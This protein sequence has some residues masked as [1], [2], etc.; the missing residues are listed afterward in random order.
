[1]YIPVL[2]LF[3]MGF[4]WGRW[5]NISYV[6]VIVMY[7]YLL[8]EELITI[9]KEIYDTK[10]YNI[11]KKKMFFIFVFI[12]FCFG[13]NPKTVIT[14]DIATNPLWKVPYNASKIIFG[15]NSYRILQDSPI[16]NWHKK[17]IE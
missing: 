10:I 14:G 12:I 5:V 9:D 6:F 7:V 2:L 16:S 17:Y 3:G 8:K 11:L 15:F 4:D 1:M 13:W